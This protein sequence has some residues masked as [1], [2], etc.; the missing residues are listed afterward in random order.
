MSSVCRL[1]DPRFKNRQTC[2]R[3]HWSPVPWSQFC[4]K[5]MPDESEPDSMGTL[6]FLLQVK[7]WPQIW[8]FRSDS[9]IY[10]PH[11]CSLNTAWWLMTGIMKRKC[12]LMEIN[13][14]KVFFFFFFYGKKKLSCSRCVHSNPLSL[15][16]YKWVCLGQV[17]IQENIHVS[18]VSKSQIPIFKKQI[19]GTSLAVQWIRLCPP[20]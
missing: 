15:P 18:E 11:R 1:R 5:Q 14:R 8:V 3:R 4:Q 13:H 17:L 12:A 19:L 7:R 9:G 20:I 6:Y 10:D 16:V 2:K